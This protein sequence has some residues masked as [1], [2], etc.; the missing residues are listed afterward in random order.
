MADPVYKIVDVVGTS[1]VSR[2]RS[3]M[4]S[5]KPLERCEI[6]ADSRLSKFVVIYAMARLT[7]IR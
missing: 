4:R 6:L 2:T 7:G 3:A 5:I 1:R